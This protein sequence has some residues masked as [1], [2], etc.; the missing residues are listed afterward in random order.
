VPLSHGGAADRMSRSSSTGISSPPRVPGIQPSIWACV[1]VSTAMP[2]SRARQC[3][4]GSTNSNDSGPAPRTR[5]RPSAPSGSCTAPGA[6]MFNT[7]PLA[8]AMFTW[9]SWVSHWSATASTPM[10][11]SPNS[12]LWS[13]THVFT[14][15]RI[16][17]SSGCVAN[18]N[19]R[20]SLSPPV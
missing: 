20:S 2:S 16:S 4:N 17:G 15:S 9:T 8:K 10:R 7:R 11:G 18:T 14:D 3:V 5:G 12:V 6:K 1:D 19:S 13:Q